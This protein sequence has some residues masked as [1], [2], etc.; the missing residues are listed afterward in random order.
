MQA[1]LLERLER[2][3]AR[4]HRREYVTSDP[5]EFVLGFERVEDREIAGLVASG[6]AFG[7][8]VQ[9]RRS[10]R[11]V[12]DR[13]GASPRDFLLN[14]SAKKLRTVFSGFRHRYVGETELCAMFDGIRVLILRHVTLHAAFA[15]YLRPEDE[16]VMPALTH[17]VEELAV[18]GG[19]RKN[20]LLPNPA[21]G[22]ACKRLHLFLRWM[23]RN[24]EI[25]PGGWTRISP[26]ML[27]MPM[28]T[29]SHRFCV[30]HGLITRRQPDG[31]AAIEATAAFRAICPE[32]PVRYDF[33]ITR[34]GICG[35]TW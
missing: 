11:G 3:Y 35:E 33:A 25:D 32:D 28:D 24:D 23:V 12:L 9:I 21:A 26:A 15:R 16:T 29:H 7:N 31:R 1:D 27:V 22:S 14:T 17:W 5:I 13:M 20:Y 8:V 10:V 18:A 19:M 30:Q 34:I 2:L 6:L 4:V